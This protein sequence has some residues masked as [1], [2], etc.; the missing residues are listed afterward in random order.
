MKTTTEI[1]NET[2]NNLNQRQV[3]GLAACEL[4]SYVSQQ[5]VAI[6]N[7]CHEDGKSKE[8]KADDSQCAT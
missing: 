5:L 8:E 7:S 1:I 3:Q 2:L 4:I 6:Y